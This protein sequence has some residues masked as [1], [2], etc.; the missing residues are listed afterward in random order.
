[1]VRM[2]RPGTAERRLR[3]LVTAPLLLLFPL[4]LAACGGGDDQPPAGSQHVAGGQGSDGSLLSIAQAQQ[5]AEQW[6]SDHEQALLKRDAAAVAHVDA[7][8]LALVEVET[9]R[10]A[11]S[12]GQGLLSGARQPAAVRVHV[13]ASQSWPVPVLA[14]YDVAGSSGSVHL[15][16]LLAKPNPSAQLI[17]TAS[18]A[19]DAPE[20]AFDTDAAGYVRM[21]A[22]ASTLAATYAQYMQAAVHGSP[23]PSPPPFAAGKLTSQTAT[24][25]AALL[26]DPSGRSKGTFNTVDLDFT[27]IAIPAPVFDLAGGAG[28]FT[29]I[30]ARRVE[31]LHP[32]QGK[33][34]LQDAQRHNYGVDL[35]PGQYPQITVQ[36]VVVLAARIPAGGAPAEAAG[37]GGGIYQEG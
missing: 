35:A 19:L 15:A 37:G 28:G 23:A 3:A 27:P 32:A 21:G 12:T 24:S 26:S 36:S 20:P 33:A 2:V 10:A 22:P 17:A 29:L 11:L 30:A 16:V 4:L 31:V 8:P 7:Q 18:A 5:G 1:M 6:W 14:V 9:V 34:L 25:D 13:P